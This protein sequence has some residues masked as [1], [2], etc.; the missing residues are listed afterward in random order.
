[1]F[2]LAPRPSGHTGG[3]LV[4]DVFCAPLSSISALFV[5]WAIRGNRL[6]PDP[7]FLAF[8]AA[9]VV[10]PYVAP[11]PLVPPMRLLLPPFVASTNP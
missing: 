2:V 10:M 9:T 7:Y 1:M 5:L 3:Q 8:C 6:V 4:V 11:E